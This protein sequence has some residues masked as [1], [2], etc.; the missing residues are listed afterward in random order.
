MLE[1]SMRDQGVF[2]FVLVLLSLS[3]F[4]ILVVGRSIFYRDGTWDHRCLLLDKLFLVCFFACIHIESGRKG[5]GSVEKGCSSANSNLKAY[6]K[7]W[8]FFIAC[9][10]S[11]EQ[12]LYIVKCYTPDLIHG[13]PGDMIARL[14][15]SRSKSPRL[16]KGIYCGSIIKA[17]EGRDFSWYKLFSIFSLIP[18]LF[19][20]ES[21]KLET[22]LEVQM[23]IHHH[24]EY[25]ATK[26]ILRRV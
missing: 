11:F 18:F 8:L 14:S 9:W 25:V 15:C 5:D 17:W 24:A 4:S 6:E 26:N 1:L 2:G 21:N 19:L 23:T 3:W 13:Q 16:I 12:H 7:S 20:M 10:K 22:H